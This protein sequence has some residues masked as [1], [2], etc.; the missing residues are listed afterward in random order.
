M[1]L[2]AEAVELTGLIGRFP[3]GK[4]EGLCRIMSEGLSMAHLERAM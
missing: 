4:R 2:V 3:V 1:I